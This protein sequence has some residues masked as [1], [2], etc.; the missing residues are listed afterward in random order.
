ME[1]KCCPTGAE[2][3]PGEQIKKA[4]KP[5]VASSEQVVKNILE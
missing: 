3:E 2:Y 1:P 4:K 5:G